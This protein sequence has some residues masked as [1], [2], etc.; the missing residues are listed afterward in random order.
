MWLFTQ[1]IGG[2]ICSQTGK[3]SLE[4]GS[5]AK[6]EKTTKSGTNSAR[7]VTSQSHKTQTARRTLYFCSFAIFKPEQQV[8]SD[9]SQNGEGW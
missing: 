4:A 2:K 9:G 3:I 1:K 5:A 6:R 8:G 7:R